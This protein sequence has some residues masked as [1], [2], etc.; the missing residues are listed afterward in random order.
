MVTKAPEAMDL[1]QALQTVKWLDQERRKDKATIANM[2]EVELAS[3]HSTLGSYI[4]NSFGL[5]S[6]N[7]AL[8]TSCRFLSGN[9]TLDVQ[10]ASSAIIRELWKKLGRTY[11]LRIVK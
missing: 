11:K 9:F 3:L 2:A 7:E 5:W 10:G 8:L 4:R 6:G 1:S